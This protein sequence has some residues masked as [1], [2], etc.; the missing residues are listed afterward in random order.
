M[1]KAP[2]SVSSE[3]VQ[4]EL[5]HLLR[6][7]FLCQS[8]YKIVGELLKTAVLLRRQFCAFS[9]LKDGFPP[10]PRQQGTSQ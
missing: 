1:Q 4:S 9:F 10:L 7:T 5:N 6:Q 2:S 8:E 3:C